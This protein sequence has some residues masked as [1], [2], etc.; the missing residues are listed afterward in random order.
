[1][2]DACWAADGA[3]LLTA[4]IDQTTRISTRR[5]DGHWCEIARPQVHGHDFST[6]TAI[7]CCHEQQQ[8]QQPRYLYACGSEEKVVRVFEAPAA[9]LDTLAMARGRPVSGGGT[10][11]G[12][13]TA[14]GALLPALGLSNKAVYRED[15]ADE[16]QA[17]QGDRSGAA[18]AAASGTGYGGGS[19]AEGPDMAPSAAPSAVQGPPLEE[20]LAQNT[21]WPE[22]HKLYGHG[23]D[24][25]CMAA[26]EAVVHAAVRIIL[27]KKFNKMHG[28]Q[29]R[30]GGGWC[31]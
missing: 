30:G 29:G 18:A 24:L 11:G 7:P 6:L 14:L 25:Y 26:G 12:A 23:S 20:H 21:L 19:Y 15:A 5:Q 16:A 13:G 1:V 3:C 10:A 2:V 31:C 8:G 9:F 4:S 22:V 17:T 27:M 28:G